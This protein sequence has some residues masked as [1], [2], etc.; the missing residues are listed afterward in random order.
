MII[1]VT[2]NRYYMIT[3][4]LFHLQSTIHIIVSFQMD[5][6]ALLIIYKQMQ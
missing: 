1:K 2:L 3:V 4:T 5:Y 6:F